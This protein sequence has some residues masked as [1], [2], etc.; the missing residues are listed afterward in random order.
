M[1]RLA[2]YSWQTPPPTSVDEDL[3]IFDDG[4]A[5]LVVR[6]PRTSMPAVG[7]YRCEP[8]KADHHILATGGPGPLVFDLLEP[9]SSAAHEALM[10]VADRVARV[11][12]KTPDAVAT[13]Y[14]QTLGSNASGS[15]A[16]SILVVGSGIRPVEFELDPAASSI[17]FDHHGQALSWSDL[18]ELPAGFT[19]PDA[20]ELGGVRRMA[21]IKPGE[22]GAIAIELPAPAG[23]TAVSAHLAGW[24]SSAP[25]D[26]PHP[27]RFGLV[28]D[29]AALES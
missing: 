2:T 19:T 3:A 23:V 25:P 18:P 4:S 5:W 20:V 16:L 9:P 15:L 29:D 6:G 28:T 24:L 10:A 12:R 21:R 8:T 17:L 26:E 14:I 13:C 22:Y 1:R 11:A 7:T 27:G